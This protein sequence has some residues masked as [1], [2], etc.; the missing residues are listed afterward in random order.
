MYYP[1]KEIIGNGKKILWFANKWTR[2]SV[3]RERITGFA[4]F[5]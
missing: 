1:E 3:F 4:L 5:V 2:V